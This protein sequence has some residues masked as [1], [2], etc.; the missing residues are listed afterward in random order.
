MYQAAD[1]IG[2]GDADDC[3]CAARLQISLHRL[4]NLLAHALIIG[5]QVKHGGLVVSNPAG[6]G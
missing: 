4:P 5:Y 2:G 3:V 1:C 6:E